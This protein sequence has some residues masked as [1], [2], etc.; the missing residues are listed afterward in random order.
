MVGA[1]RAIRLAS[2]A[3]SRSPGKAVVSQ[4][5]RKATI[6]FWR[7][8]AMPP[9][10]FDRFTAFTASSSL[11]RWSDADLLALFLQRRG[12]SSEDAFAE[13]V[14]RYGP[15]VLRVCRSIVG[16]EHQAQDAFQATF[17]VLARK[18]RGLWV[19]DS[20]GP[21]LHGVARRMAS[22]VRKS[23]VRRRTFE[24]RVC[25][26]AKPAAA[27]DESGDIDERAAVIQEEI[28]RRPELYRSPVVLCD[29]QGQTHQEA[30]LR[31][32]CPVGT[33]KSR[34]SRG[35]EQ[36]RRRLTR[37]GIALSSVVLASLLEEKRAIAK[38]TPRLVRATASAASLFE[39]G[40]PV[41]SF[42]IP[43]PRAEVLARA[44]S[45]A[46]AI[47]SSRRVSPCRLFLAASALAAV[48][49]VA[50]PASRA[51]LGGRAT[52]RSLPNGSIASLRWTRSYGGSAAKPM[53]KGKRLAMQGQLVPR[54]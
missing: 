3:A 21:W 40:L 6:E 33:V 32:G 30:A 13:L 42:C 17:L 14:E 4:I 44:E 41:R 31:L 22:D 7:P 26:D 53:E 43:W 1:S 46:A 23:M 10:S 8:E 18:G 34:Q 19:R 47:P 15:L 5:S 36:L 25:A 35:R 37:R 9:F 11:D 38:I 16:D 54:T 12:A 24:R 50:E 45:A 28:C 49:L 2:P 48:V 52:A 39:S 51:W 29:M 27:I 20:L